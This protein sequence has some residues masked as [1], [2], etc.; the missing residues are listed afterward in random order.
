[1]TTN[2]TNGLHTFINQFDFI[3]ESLMDFLLETALRL[4]ALTET[5]LFLL[6]EGRSGRQFCGHQDLVNAFKSGKLEANA[7]KDDEVELT[8]TRD[9]KPIR[10]RR[11]VGRDGENPSAEGCH[12]G[13]KRKAPRAGGEAVASED[14]GKRRRLSA[15]HVNASTSSSSTNEVPVIKRER[16]EILDCGSSTCN[17]GLA[18]RTFPS[19]MIPLPRVKVLREI[20]DPAELRG[21]SRFMPILSPD[22]CIE[23][24]LDG[25]REAIHDGVAQKIYKHR[26][27]ICYQQSDCF[28]EGAIPKHTVKVILP[29]CNEI[30]VVRHRGEQCYP[31]PDCERAAA[32]EGGQQDQE[33]RWSINSWENI[34]SRLHT[35]LRQHY[36]RHHHCFLNQVYKTPEEVKEF[37]VTARRLRC[38]MI[39]GPSPV[40]EQYS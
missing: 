24:V 9:H 33:E 21:G 11:E 36:A 6:I 34:S 35:R 12:V 13:F 22:E 40:N 19:S 23:P 1:M 31:C 25:D 38:Q 26:C 32:S 30:A 37:Y 5:R 7:D 3:E 29:W 39:H 2:L 15:D 27:E 17:R 8:S 14:D 10:K 18:P 20:E 16:D 4:G 28:I